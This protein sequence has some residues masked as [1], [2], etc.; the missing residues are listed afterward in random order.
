MFFVFL[1]VVTVVFL[2]LFLSVLHSFN[3]PTKPQVYPSLLIVR[4]SPLQSTT[5]HPLPAPSNTLTSSLPISGIH[6]RAWQSD[7]HENRYVRSWSHTMSRI[8]AV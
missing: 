1:F 5:E 7:E 3:M 6:D 2:F 4:M 8:M